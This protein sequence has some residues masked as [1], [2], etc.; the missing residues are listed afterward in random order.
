MSFRMLPTLAV[1]TALACPT[2][3][4]AK[5]PST[6]SQVELPGPLK[7]TLLKP[8]GKILAT[9]LILP[10]SGP[11]NRDGENPLGV[12]ASTYRL[13]AE[14]LAGKGVATLRM[15]KRGMF[16]SA[17]AAA[18]PNRVFIAD[19]AA[20][21]NAWAAKAK[22]ETGVSCVWLIGHSEGA[23][24]AL[25]AAQTGKDLCGIVLISGPG[26]PLGEV[27][28]QQ[29]EANPA[30]APIL[31][32]A[33][34]AL[35]ELEAGRR[36]DVSPLHPALAQGLFNPVVQ[37]FL[38]AAFRYDP[39]ALVRSYKGPVLVVQ[40]TTDIQV[41]LEDAQLLTG[42]RKGVAFAEI[43]GAN[44]VLKTAPMDRAANIATYSDP[45]LPLA[46]GVID[47]IASFLLKPHHVA[48]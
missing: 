37:D 10:G 6:D 30:N 5:D 19:L 4:P 12:S 20:D 11:T 27:L 9:A 33:L 21:A 24:V 31:P 2:A 46:P 15:D 8:E 32:P 28:R 3:V 35:D 7:G 29:L 22:A 14:G 17:P 40:G 42:A 1:I 47:P 25:V 13:L 18:D 39:V 48:N 38:I 45:A 16:A 41:S 23:L 34:K 26:R 36:A 43:I 44:H